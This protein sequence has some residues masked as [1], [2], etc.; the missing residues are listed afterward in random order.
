MFDVV[1]LL[2]IDDVYIGMLVV[3]IGVDLILSVVFIMY[4]DKLCNNND[5]VLFIR[6]VSYECMV[7]FFDDV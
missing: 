4:N 1:K 6:L 5:Y 3:D 2:K 7:K